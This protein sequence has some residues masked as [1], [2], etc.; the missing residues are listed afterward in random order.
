MFVY[1]CGEFC[2]QQVLWKNPQSLYSYAP[3]ASGVIPSA[4]LRVKGVSGGPLTR[5][6]HLE[7]NQVSQPAFRK[8]KK[9]LPILSSVSKSTD[10]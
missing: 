9:C 1:F 8:I 7:Q 3:H 4:G 10:F 5:L 2:C 6:L